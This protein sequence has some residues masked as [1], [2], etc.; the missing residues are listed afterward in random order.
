MRVPYLLLTLASKLSA[1]FLH[2][3]LVVTGVLGLLRCR[4][5]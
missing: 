1:R 3:K 5:S 4:A 2:V